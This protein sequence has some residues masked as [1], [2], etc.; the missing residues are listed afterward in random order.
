MPQLMGSSTSP[1]QP[2][3]LPG[4]AR[5]PQ[6]FVSSIPNFFCPARETGFRLQPRAV[7]QDRRGHLAPTLLKPNSKAWQMR[8]TGGDRTSSI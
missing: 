8:S 3:Q 4:A 7:I 5:L 6:S 2:G 1:E